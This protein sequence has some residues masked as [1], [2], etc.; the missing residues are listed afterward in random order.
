MKNPFIYGKAVTGEEFDR[1]T[2]V[3]QDAGR[4]FILSPRRYGKSSLI[5]TLLDSLKKQ[6]F[7]TAY[8]DL[9]RVTS[10]REPMGLY[11]T[12]IGSTRK[13][14]QKEDKEARPSL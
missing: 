3:A 9:S 11:T 13:D 6:G 1:L 14:S 8:I 7:L 10:Y 4:I 12:D 5:L 2:R